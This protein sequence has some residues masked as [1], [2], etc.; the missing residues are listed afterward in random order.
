MNISNINLTDSDHGLDLI[1]SEFDELK[2][3]NNC[4][5]AVQHSFLRKTWILESIKYFQLKLVH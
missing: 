5:V 3:L 1:R 4:I 2:T